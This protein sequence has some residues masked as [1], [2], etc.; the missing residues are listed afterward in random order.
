MAAGSNE[1]TAATNIT[2]ALW[3]NLQPSEVFRCDV[4][5]QARNSFT[6]IRD[7]SFGG[8]LGGGNASHLL[9]ATP[10]RHFLQK[11]LQHQRIQANIKRGCLYA[12]A[13]SATNYT[14]GRS[15]LFI[16]GQKG[17]PCGTAVG[18]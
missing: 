7:L 6:W 9:D 4:F 16:Q 14:S 12:L 15:Y 10:L 13:I 17:H 1:F 11:H 5:S 3:A 2:A 8:V 18:G